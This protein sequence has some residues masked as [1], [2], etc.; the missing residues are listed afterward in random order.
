MYEQ[1]RRAGIGFSACVGVGNQVD[2]G[3]GELLAYFAQRPRPRTPWRCTSRASGAPGR[4]QGRSGRLPRSQKALLLLRADLLDQDR[5][6]VATHTRARRTSSRPAARNVWQAATR[7]N[8]VGF[9]QDLVDG[10]RASVARNGGLGQGDHLMAAVIRSWRSTGRRRAGLSMA[11]LSA[12]DQSRADERISPGRTAGRGAGNPGDPR[13]RGRGS[14]DAA[15]PMR[16]GWPPWARDRRR[17]A[18][19]RDTDREL[20]RRTGGFQLIKPHR[21]ATG[22]SCSR[23]SR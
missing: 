1:A 3:L 13:R 17:R 19:R 12:R 5:Q 23:R 11:T 2:V 7:G 21:S 8:R 9:T 22:W 15:G 16:G 6:R 10:S 14:P 20:G 18:V 4:V